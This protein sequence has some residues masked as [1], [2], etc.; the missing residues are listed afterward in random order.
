VI[1][2]TTI[3][4]VSASEK[5]RGLAELDAL[6]Q[7]VAA[8]PGGALGATNFSPELRFVF[9]RGQRGG[10]RSHFGVMPDLCSLAKIVRGGTPLGAIAGRESLVC[11]CDAT[12]K[13]GDE[14]V[15]QNDTLNRN[16]LSTAIALAALGELAKPGDYERLFASHPPRNHQ[17][18]MAADGQ[19][20]L[21]LDYALIREGLFVLPVNPR[22]ISTAYTDRDL[23]GTFAAVDRACAA[24]R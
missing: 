10:A 2:N 6:S 22:F 12:L 19:A 15:Y 17:D 14:C 13:G 5:L 8:L 20:L 1:M 9:S 24:P 4:F 7:A 11:W 3:H 21:A 23:E 16:P 18:V